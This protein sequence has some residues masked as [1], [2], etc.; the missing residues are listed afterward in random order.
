MYCSVC[1]HPEGAEIVEDWVFS[2]SLRLTAERYG[3]G[4]RSLQRHLDQCIP[5]IMAE[6]EYKDYRAAFKATAE[7]LRL[8]FESANKNPQPIKRR[9]KSIITKPVVFT[10]SRRAWKDKPKGV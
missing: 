1:T 9:P 4:Y 5:S 3:V 7:W 10:W 6:Y 8:H 2:Q